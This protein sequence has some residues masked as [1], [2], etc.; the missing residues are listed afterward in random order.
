[1][2]ILPLAKVS[3]IMSVVMVLWIFVAITLILIVL[4]QKGRG[5]GVGAAFG[6]G[7]AGGVLGT[8]TGDFLTWVTIALVVIFLTSSVIMAKFYRPVIS[9]DFNTDQ[10]VTSQPI[11]PYQPVT[12]Q[13]TPE[14]PETVPAPEK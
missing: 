1:M 7:G 12:D 3:F 13:P 14:E 11:Q 5:G 2:M 8:K 4:I 10:P 9:D 6:G